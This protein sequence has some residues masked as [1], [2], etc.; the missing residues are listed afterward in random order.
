MSRTLLA[1]LCAIALSGCGNGNP[2]AALAM[3]KRLESGDI[4]ALKELE[5]RA[6]SD[7]WAALA[8]GRAQQLGIGTKIDLAGAMYSYSEA[9]KVPGA[10]FNAGLIYSQDLIDGLR[11]DGTPE[12]DNAC[13]R[14]SGKSAT[15]KAVDCFTRAAKSAQPIQARI[16]LGRLYQTGQ[17]DLKPNPAQA[18]SWYAKAADEHDDEGRYQYGMCLIS[19]EGAQQDV[20]NGTYLLM[21]AAKNY[22]VGAIQALARLFDEGEDK[23]KAG[24]WML[25]LAKV[26]PVSRDK[27]DR[28]M[29]GL[30]NKEVLHARQQLET[31]LLAHNAPTELDSHF[32]ASLPVSVYDLQK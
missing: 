8:V 4:S 14:P 31:W 16:A 10:W 22:H 3:E 27:V 5:A 11:P 21:E 15:M 7:P 12:P 18:C 13:F 2:S 19:G 20:R 24:F 17:Q 30:T 28:F 29:A 9:Q 23:S 25:L 6:S 1:L 26:D 32:T